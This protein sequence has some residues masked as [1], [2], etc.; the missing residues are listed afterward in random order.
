MQKRLV[1]F[2]WKMNPQTEQEAVDLFGA[3]V[4]AAK[5]AHNVSVIVAPPFPFLSAIDKRW[6]IADALLRDEAIVQLAAQDVFWERDGAFTG[7]VSPEMEKNLGV[8][9]V[10]IGHSERRRFL[11]ETD[12]MVHQKLAKSFESRVT[13][14]LCIGEETRD[15]ADIPERVGDELRSAIAEISASLLES[16]I[17]AY[18][19]VWAIGSGTPDTPEDMHQAA[20][21]IRKVLRDAA[22]ESVSQKARILYGG[23]VNST[24]IASYF[25]KT[26]GEVA[27]VL[28]GGASLKAEGVS[29]IIAAAAAL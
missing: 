16:L 10:I 4:S 1:V 28:V 18:E 5:S 7:E 21:Y 3:T 12:E 27:G 19:P 29:K 23:S 8:S 26:G 2:N 24:N 9:Y 17:V 14:I 22:G 11:G 25:E 20:V 6:S 15:G 13:P